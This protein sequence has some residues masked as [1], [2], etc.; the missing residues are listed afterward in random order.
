VALAPCFGTAALTTIGNIG[1]RGPRKKPHAEKPS[2]AARDTGLVSSMC[3]AVV[4]QRK[5]RARF[6]RQSNRWPGSRRAAR[7]RARRRYAYGSSFA[8][9]R[10]LSDLNPHRGPCFARERCRSTLCLPHL[11]TGEGHFM[12]RQLGPSWPVCAN[13]VDGVSR[14]VREFRGRGDPQQDK[15]PAA[16]C[17]SSVHFRFRALWWVA[18]SLIV[19]FGRGLRSACARIGPQ[20][21]S[22]DHQRCGGRPIAIRAATADLILGAAWPTKLTSPR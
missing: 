14:R 8:P 5:P 16:F 12:V 4:R 7:T 13:P 10:R 18:P 9:K 22:F 15:C 3:N 19:L 6:R 21:F 11:K 2:P 20:L 17:A 1:T